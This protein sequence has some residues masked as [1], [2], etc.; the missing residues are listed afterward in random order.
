MALSLVVSEIFNVEKCR[1]L[2][3]GKTLSGGIPQGSRLGPLSFIVPIDDLKAAC[4]V[5]KFVDDTTFSELIPSTGSV[6][7]MPSHLTSALLTWT[8]NNDMQINTYKTKEMILGSINLPPLLTSS[9]AIERVSTFK[10]LGIHLDR[11]LTNLSWSTHINSITSKA[12]RDQSLKLIL[13]TIERKKQ[14][15]WDANITVACP[16]QHCSL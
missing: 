7:N 11:N 10:L 12:S 14:R 3:I 9:G 4:E 15:S 5:H 13:R 2:E 8:A 16:T 1:D 6:S